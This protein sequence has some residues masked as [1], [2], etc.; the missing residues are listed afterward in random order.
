MEKQ[1]KE[2]RTISV[3][4]TKEEHDA[5]IAYCEQEHWKLSAFLRHCI[6]QASGVLNAA[7]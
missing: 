5:V 7:E 6:R 1:K 4:L 2:S 3:R